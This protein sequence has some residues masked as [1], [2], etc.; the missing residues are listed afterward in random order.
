MKFRSLGPA[1][2]ALAVIVPMAAC[3]SVTDPEAPALTVQMTTDLDGTA[4]SS[5][6]AS[7]ALLSAVTEAGAAQMGPISLED[8]ESIIVGIEEVRV[9]ATGD[10][11]PGNG[12]GGGWVALEDTPVE[13]DLMALGD[14]TTLGT[15]PADA[16]VEGVAALRI[17]FSSAEIFF[18]EE[19]DGQLSAEL[20][21][22][23]GKV[24]IPTPG[25]VAD[26]TTLELAFLADASVKK[27]IR[28]G[29]GYMMPPVITVAGAEDDLDD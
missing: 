2:L 20:I 4:S 27:V 14:H 21:I 26:G 11:E 22:P 23:S 9:V 16:G 12:N 3:D 29:M 18:F 25:L 17:I 24:N 6:V 19:I 28:S 7:P 8:V 15:L 5:L 13:L 10:E 1:A